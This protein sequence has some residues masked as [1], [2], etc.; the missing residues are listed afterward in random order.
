MKVLSNYVENVA[1]GQKMQ[2][3][4]KAL[5]GCTIAMQKNNS[6]NLK[7]HFTK[8]SFI[9]VEQMQTCAKNA[10]FCIDY[11][12]VHTFYIKYAADKQ[13]ANSDNFPMNLDIGFMK[14]TL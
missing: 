12:L 11:R 2:N 7:V 14:Q 8:H 3:N 1:T 6:A 10:L 13:K 5:R 9:F 4:F